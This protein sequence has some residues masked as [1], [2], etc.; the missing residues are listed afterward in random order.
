MS[1]GL[2]T[3]LLSIPEE[4]KKAKGVVWGGRGVEQVTSPG[5]HTT[6]T[7]SLPGPTHN[8]SRTRPASVTIYSKQ[9]IIET[10]NKALHYP[11][12]RVLPDYR[13]GKLFSG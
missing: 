6:R 5:H 8:T 3:G 13:L 4:T 9:I 1:M 2:P 7:S 11:F 10:H 12:R